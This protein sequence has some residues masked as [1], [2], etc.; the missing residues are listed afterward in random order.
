VRERVCDL[1]LC[2][3]WVVQAVTLSLDDRDALLAVAESGLRCQSRAEKS[4]SG[5]R[6]TV[7]VLQGRYYFEATCCDEGL[8]RVGWSTKAASLELGTD[9][10]SFGYGGTANKSHARQFDAYGETYGQ[11]RAPH[12]PPAEGTCTLESSDGGPR[13][14]H[15]RA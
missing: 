11:V 13:G 5:G 14:P 4:W 6:A 8:C 15:A 2:G 1:S 7:G 3:G 10:Q 12:R 9:K